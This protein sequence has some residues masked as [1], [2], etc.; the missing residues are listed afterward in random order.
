MRTTELASG[1]HTVLAAVNLFMLSGAHGRFIPQGAG[2]HT[3]EARIQTLEPDNWMKEVTLF[4]H[5]T[6]RRI[7]LSELE[8]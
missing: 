6:R 7:P 4:G 2:G 8:L 5:G 1:K 3:R